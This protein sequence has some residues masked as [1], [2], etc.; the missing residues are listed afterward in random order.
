[1]FLLFLKFNAFKWFRNA[2]LSD[3]INKAN[4]VGVKKNGYRFAINSCRVVESCGKEK[5]FVTFVFLPF[6]GVIEKV[7]NPPAERLK[8]LDFKF[9]ES[10]VEHFQFL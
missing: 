5:Q 10:F 1:M 9:R 6:C 7:S 3:F 2:S 4:P 8:E